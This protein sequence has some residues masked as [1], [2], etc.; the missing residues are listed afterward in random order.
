MEGQILKAEA[1]LVAARATAE[2]PAVASDHQA[3][4][5]RLA[6]LALEQ[7]AVEHLYARWAELEAKARTPLKKKKKKKSS[8]KWQE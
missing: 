3:L 4:A 8:R 6:A 5:A 7:A 2:D 1:R